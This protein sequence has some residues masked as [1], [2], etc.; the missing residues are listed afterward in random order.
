MK[1]MILAAAVIGVLLPGCGRPAPAVTEIL[2]AGPVES[3]KIPVEP[4]ITG[5]IICQYN[6]TGN[7]MPRELAVAGNE[8]ILTTIDRDN[9]LTIV[10]SCRTDKETETTVT[11]DI[12]YPPGSSARWGAPKAVTADMLGKPVWRKA[13]ADPD[14]HEEVFAIEIVPVRQN[15]QEHKASQSSGSE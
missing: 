3:W 12:E 11:F 2:K 8:F 4:Q 14:T 15:D 13:W 1:L 5:P 6:V 10:H 7:D 9:T